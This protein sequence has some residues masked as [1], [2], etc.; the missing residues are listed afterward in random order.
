MAFDAAV[1]VLLDLSSSL[2]ECTV[3]RH[4]HDHYSTI[5]ILSSCTVM[6]AKEL[7]FVLRILVSTQTLVH[8]QTIIKLA[9]IICEVIV[10]LFESMDT[11]FCKKGCVWA[12][13]LNFHRTARGNTV[14]EKRSASRTKNM[15]SA[16]SNEQTIYLCDTKWTNKFFGVER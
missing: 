6:Y 15:R 4:Y 13:K 14:W 16:A 5:I 3:F 9:R 7:Y 8:I 11:E 12:T 10:V 2:R 1:P